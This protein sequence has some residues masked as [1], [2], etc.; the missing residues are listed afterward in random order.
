MEPLLEISDLHKAYGSLTVLDGVNVTVDSGQVVV[1]IGPSGC[2]KS[3]LLRCIN[4]LE[5]IQSGSIR[6]GG[7]QIT[8]PKT[9]WSKVRQ[10]IGMV[11]QDYELF[12][13]MTVMDNILLAP[14]RVQHRRKAEAATEAE[15]L[16]NRVGLIDKKAVYPR[17]LSGGQKQR[18]AIVRS[19]I[20]HPELMLFDEVTAALDPEMV[21]EVLDCL[22][23]LAEDGMTMLI[24]THEMSF[25]RAVADEVLLIDEGR[26][27]EI[28]PPEQFF[29]HP[30]SERAKTFLASLEFSPRK[31]SHA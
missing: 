2:G 15:Q 3:T 24:V 11:F 20:L 17:Q 8:S 6:L 31:E 16:L 9:D 30:E 23:E 26:V 18:I 7:E 22:V 12:P 1:V 29:T 4:G 10:R 13:H 28:A 19:L 27:A 25:A 5:P 14:M 21:R